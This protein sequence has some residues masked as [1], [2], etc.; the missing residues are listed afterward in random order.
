[1]MREE[2]EDVSDARFI[3]K[4][5]R[6]QLSLMGN[7]FKTRIKERDTAAIIDIIA[8]QNSKAAQN[9]NFQI[10]VLQLT[11]LNAPQALSKI[12]KWGAENSHTPG[13]CE[14]DAHDG[15]HPMVVACQ[16]DYHGCMDHLYKHGF[17]M[18]LT[19][20]EDEEI[21]QIRKFL[22]FK[23]K[24]NIHYL[25][26]EFTEHAAFLKGNNSSG[27]CGENY[28]DLQRVD[29]IRKVYHLMQHADEC[30]EDF[31]GTSNMGKE[32]I[33]IKVKLE[34]FLV[35][36]L[37]LC[38]SMQEVDTLLEHNPL[39]DDD[40]ELDEHENNWQKALHRGYKTFVS[41]PNFQQYIW[42]EM[43]GAGALYEY[44]GVP[45]ASL[46]DKMP[47]TGLFCKVRVR[48]IFWGLKNI[49]LTLLSFLLCYIPVVLADLFRKGDIMF[50]THTAKKGRST[51][52]EMQ[53]NGTTADQSMTKK[54]FDFFR[55]RMHI[56]I[57]RMIPYFATELLY[58][59]LLF[60]A[61]WKPVN[62]L[63]GGLAENNDSQQL[64]LV[65]FLLTIIYLC[66]D[67]VNL[68][69]PRHLQSTW[70]FVELIA[71]LLLVLGTIIAVISHRD[72]D[73]NVSRANLS[74]NS[75]VNVGMTMV[76]F[77]AGLQYF[78]M[79]RWLGLI[80]ATGP[81]VL[82]VLRVIKDAVRLVS[83]YFV[84]FVAHAIAIWSLYKPFRY[85]GTASGENEELSNY[86]APDGLKSQRSLMSTLFWRIIASA[87]GTSVE[88][89]SQEENAENF[90]M[91]FSH[92]M[93]LVLWGVYQIIIYVLM[94][95]LLIAVMNTS[96]SAIWEN[97][98]SEWRYN[99]TSFYA[100]FL[101]PVM[102]FPVPFRWAYY[103]GKTVYRCKGSKEAKT[104]DHFEYYELVRRIILEK[105]DAQE[106]GNRNLLVTN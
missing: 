4:S 76:S 12:L 33:A 54:L 60:L 7:E 96:Y 32:Y 77:G 14:F 26:L 59:L 38:G 39:D 50:V 29:P 43:T 81:M 90:S 53:A 83:I 87:D 16:H 11:N 49:P 51:D 84:L 18:R 31:Q 9:E 69:R 52:K 101:H 58:L 91:E 34:E 44:H 56:P 88:I 74:G 97:I 61:I 66:D 85:A 67:I 47:S 70:S 55:L 21:D 92:L 13:S 46:V 64:V 63:K 25:T 104:L 98:H 79:L 10:A 27:T 28:E 23:A 1:M 95:N 15:L 93:G 5:L 17:R 72:A 86:V 30:M 100:T 37:N 94:L 45:F 105:R 89:K 36:I 78:L 19:D 102:I 103:L 82:C 75:A 68:F 42:S 24:S 65:T 22:K 71:H 99:K 48:R 35:D 20:T 8:S 62:P 57:L 106:E 3:L 40:D 6:S 2:I 41:H 80:E 73:P